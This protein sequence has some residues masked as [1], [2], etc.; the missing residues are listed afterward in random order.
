MMRYFAIMILIG[1]FIFCGLTLLH[2][3]VQGFDT[4]LGKK[5]QGRMDR[6]INEF[7]YHR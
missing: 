6:V 7:T 1:T 5:E 4:D 3:A 2:L